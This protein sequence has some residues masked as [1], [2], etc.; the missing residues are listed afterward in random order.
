MKARGVTDKNGIQLYEN[1][2]FIYTAHNGYLLP[3][4][5][6]TIVYND[7]SA[8]WAYELDGVYNNLSDIHELRHDFLNHIE[9]KI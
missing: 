6:S 3:S 1:D 8:C 4:F 2:K 5:E 9:I 7:D